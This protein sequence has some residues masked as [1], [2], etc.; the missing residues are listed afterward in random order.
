MLSTTTGC[1][2]PMPRV[3]LPP[4]AACTDSACCASASGCRGYVGTTAVPS[5]MRSV[6]A[7]ASVSAVSASR[8]H[9]ICGT[10][11]LVTP[12]PPPQRPRCCSSSTPARSPP[13]SETKMPIFNEISA[14]SGR[15]RVAELLEHDGLHH[16][17]HREQ[18]GV[19][20]D[21]AGGEPFLHVLAE[22]GPVVDVDFVE[23]EVAVAH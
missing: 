2:G 16:R 19:D 23:R 17:L 10:H 8:L 20:R 14:A 3:S 22:L 12:F 9:G 13:V 21:G 1:D 6:T 5:S 7:A 11:A 15:D 4:L 18:V